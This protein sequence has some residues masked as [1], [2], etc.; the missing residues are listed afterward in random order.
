MVFFAIDRIWCKGARDYFYV[1]ESGVLRKG[2]FFW[3][4]SF[5]YLYSGALSDTS[6]TD[7]AARLCVETKARCYGIIPARVWRVAIKT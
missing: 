1:C 5:L 3:R 2:A 7:E 6:W 4:L